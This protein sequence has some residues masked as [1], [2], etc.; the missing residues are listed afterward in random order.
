MENLKTIAL[1]DANVIYSAPLRDFL[2][3][4]ARANLYEPK[5]TNEILN[6]WIKNLKKNRPDLIPSNLER[7]KT[8]M[9]FYF[10]EAEINGYEK[11]IA[12]LFLPDRSDRHV[13]AAAIKGGANLIVTNNLKDFPKRNLEQYDIEAISPDDFVLKLI[14]NNKQSVLHV[15]GILVDSLQKPLKTPKQVLDTLEKCGL[16]K[17]AK[18][19]R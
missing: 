2:L 4:L 19:L 13:F 7:T 17:S 16:K 6:E 8:L 1:L 18:L 12:T 15:L 3:R 11:L 9:D 14:A 5:W 10:P